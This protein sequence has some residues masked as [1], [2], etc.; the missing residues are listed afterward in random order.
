MR[1][2]SSRETGPS[3]RKKPC[4]RLHE[5]TKCVRRCQQGDLFSKSSSRK[6]RDYRSKPALLK[7]GLGR[8]GLFPLLPM[9]ITPVNLLSSWE[10]LGNE[11]AFLVWTFRW[12]A[13]RWQRCLEQFIRK[14]ADSCIYLSYLMK[15]IFVSGCWNLHSF[16]RNDCC[17]FLFG[18]THLMFKI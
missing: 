7:T 3:A 9:G 5:W 18:T 4:D 12:R 2:E 13:P 15:H 17:I 8:V 6:C 1:R 11:A 14:S 10:I 16:L